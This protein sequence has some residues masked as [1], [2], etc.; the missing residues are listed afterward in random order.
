MPAA[1][2]RIEP[3]DLLP[4]SEFARIRKDRRAELLPIKRLRRIELGPVGTVYFECYETMLFQVQEMLLIEK[5]GAA[6]VPDELEAYNPLIPQGSELVAT[7]MFEIDDEVRREATLAR[8]GGVEDCF[9][10][11]IGADRIMG[12]PEGDIERTRDDGKASSVHFVRFPLTPD[13]VAKFRDPATAIAVGC[14]HERYSHQAGLSPATRAEL[15]R[16]LA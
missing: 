13:H 9:F 6:Q 16:D 15:S 14:S 12:V 4:D 1:E 5:G 2:R 11:Q 7:I 8:L 3:A 10:I